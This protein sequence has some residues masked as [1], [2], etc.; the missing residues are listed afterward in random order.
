MPELSDAD[1]GFQGALLDDSAV[2]FGKQLSDTDVGFSATPATDAAL[3]PGTA[4]LNEI[5]RGASLE[6][7]PWDAAK[8]LGQLA[9]GPL[10]GAYHALHQAYD[11]VAGTPIEQAIPESQTLKRLED[12]KSQYGGSSPQYRQAA[13]EAAQEILPNVALLGAG[14]R[15]A[16][17]GGEINASGIESTEPVPES[18]VRP[19][20]GETPPFQPV[21]EGFARA[22][23][24]RPTG[25]VVEQPTQETAPVTFKTRVDPVYKYESFT[26][27]T[28]GGS[29]LGDISGN[30]LTIQGV[31]VDIP[32]RGIGTRLYQKVIDEAEQRGL[33]VQSDKSVSPEA[34]NLY[35]SL[36]RKGYDVQK[37]PNAVLDEDGD[38]T[39]G[40][41]EGPVYTIK[42]KPTVPPGDER[43][44]GL[45]QPQGNVAPETGVAEAGARQEA[46]GELFGIKPGTFASREAEL[47]AARERAGNIDPYT[48]IQKA[49]KGNFNT[50]E[51]AD[52]IVEQERLNN[53]AK[54]AELRNGL[55]SP[56]YTEAYQDA[57]VFAEGATKPAGTR[58]GEQLQMFQ[59][60]L[61]PDY[62]T[63]TGLRDIAERRLGREVTA[64]EE[65]GFRNIVK[66]VREADTVAATETNGAINRTR[67]YRPKERIS[68]EEARRN[69][70]DQISE[71]TK[72][73]I[74]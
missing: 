16:T 6:T 67:A 33:I 71:L 74:L 21:D 64:S 49:Q 13:G 4:T 29:M 1:V 45:E 56:E 12:I 27:E 30:A 42:P 14:V 25:E 5:A 44:A 19:S 68:F 3:I 59:E 34:Q 55:D 73:C 47:S 63:V 54:Q 52:I 38:L 72:D 17:K 36:E 24:A 26:A 62:T 20:V 46:L 43:Y 50:G 23:G 15:A 37:N 60:A 65:A 53:I 8:M 51:L 69:I 2:G 32:N 70:A 35:D 61:P 40:P 7:V 58:S 18:Q 9:I 57:K 11:V 28:E 31:G 66:D 22:R 39:T 10:P 48:L 41:G